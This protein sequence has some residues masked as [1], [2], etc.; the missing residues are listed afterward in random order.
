MPGLD[1]QI[2]MHRLNIKPDI[3]PVKQQQRRFHPNIMEAIEA[4]V[5]KL[6]AC[7]FTR[8]G[9]HP[10][11]VAN[12][13]SVLKKNGKIRVCIDYRDLNV[14]CP[15]D[16]FLLPITDVMIDNT[17]SF[18]RMSFMGGLSGYNQ[19]KMYPRDE[20]HTSFRMPLG[21]YCYTLILKSAGATYQRAISIIF[22]NHLRKMMECYVDDIVVKSCDKNDH[23]HDLKTIFEIMRTH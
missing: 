19:F 15:K 12:I 14:A 21:I 13:V 20:K 8:E 9:Q 5:H 18:E 23:L 3:K 1:L 7:G 17:C 6:I 2:A 4:K 11:W 10:D 22:H 16:E